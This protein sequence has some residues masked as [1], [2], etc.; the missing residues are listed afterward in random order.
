MKEISCLLCSQYD[1]FYYDETVMNDE[2]IIFLMSLGLT[3]VCVRTY[4][5]ATFLA[6][7]STILVFI[8]TQCVPT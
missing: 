8:I 5:C 6:Q 1:T 4:F 2:E 7:V 3:V